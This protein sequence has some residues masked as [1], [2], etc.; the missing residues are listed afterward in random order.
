[1]AGS[2]YVFPFTSINSHKLTS[3]ARELPYK[4]Q[5]ESVLWYT[6]DNLG[7]ILSLEICSEADTKDSELTD[8]D[9][10]LLTA[11]CDSI[12]ELP[13]SSFKAAVALAREQVDE[14]CKVTDTDTAKLCS[15]VKWVCN[16]G[17]LLRPVGTYPYRYRACVGHSYAPV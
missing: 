1:M 11:L 14:W 9:W 16:K 7:L 3:D 10:E 17:A 4:A 15:T 6:R 8:T 13:S 2:E 5:C 12:Q